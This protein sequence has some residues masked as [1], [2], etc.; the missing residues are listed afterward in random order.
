M[1]KF[2]DSFSN[3]SKFGPLASSKEFMDEIER[4]QREAGRRNIERELDNEKKRRI[5]REAKSEIERA[6]ERES[7]RRFLWKVTILSAVVG[8]VVAS[9]LTI[10][11]EHFFK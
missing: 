11:L 5:E 7:D 6:Q 8:S 2:E 10:I 4:Q 3:E 1:S 9:V